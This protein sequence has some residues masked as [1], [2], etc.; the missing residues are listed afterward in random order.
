ME[1]ITL[2]PSGY[3][4]CHNEDE[5]ERAGD[6]ISKYLMT[7]S[8]DRERLNLN[9]RYADGDTKRKGDE[10][11]SEETLKKI[12]EKTYGPVD[13]K[14]KERRNLNKRKPPRKTG[15]EEINYR[16]EIN[17]STQSDEKYLFI[18]GYNLIYEWDEL[19]KLSESD[20]E[21]ARERLIEILRN[22]AGYTGEHVILVFD[23]YNVKG[24]TGSKESSDPIEVVYTE[25]AETADMYIEKVTHGMAGKNRVRVV[26]SDG[27]E[28]LMIMIMIFILSIILAEKFSKTINKLP[29]FQHFKVADRKSVV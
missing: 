10:N 11:V 3:D 15:F 2:F 6:D 9:S 21:A 1:I 19:K 16:V 28:Q 27:M 13:R 20:F 24:G 5:V 12:F 26:T 17:K 25:E 23:A 14:R 7:A 4:I 22:Y 8:C 18:D 29:T